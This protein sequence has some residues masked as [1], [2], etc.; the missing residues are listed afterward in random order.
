MDKN[1]LKQ[2]KLYSYMP[3]L[4]EFRKNVNKMYIWFTFFLSN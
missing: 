4:N 2:K 3:L 1:W